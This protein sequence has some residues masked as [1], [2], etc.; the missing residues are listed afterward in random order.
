MAQMKILFSIS[1]AAMLIAGCAGPRASTAA[2]PGAPRVF[3]LNASALASNRGR[4]STELQPAY[5]SL[6]RDADKALREGPFSVMEKK[7]NPPSGDR[8][9][10]MSLAPYFWPNPA[11]K[12]GLPYIRKDGQTNPEVKEYKDKE[13]MPRL[14]ELVHTLGLA[15]YFSGDERYAEHAG[16]LL[17]TWFLDTATRMN[18]NLNFAQAIKGQNT[19]RGA[20]LIDARHFVKV[21]DAIGL[22]GASRSWT[23]ADQ[24]GMQQWFGAFL[25]WMQTSPIGLDELD[26]RNNHGTFYDALRLSM[27][28]YI[29]STDLARRIV[30]SAQ[31]RLDYQMD[32]EGKFPKEMERTIA[33]HYNTFNL[34]AYFQIASMAEKLGIDFWKYRT[35]SGA[36]LEKGFN[37]L[38]PYLS[39]EKEW[40]GQQIKSFDFDEA[41][42]ILLSA[43]RKY[44][45]TPCPQKVDALAAGKAASLRWKLLY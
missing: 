20:G 29:D 37:Y 43:A 35:P 40:T 10:Y 6:L 16:K 33:L 31:D 14:C 2:A 8:H 5:A 36:S 1:L 39:K 26:A 23:T 17:R 32:A 27:A 7:N 4:T 34:D 18:P 9:D 38:Y 24:H 44:N 12:D 42:P 45:C 21:V 30:R 13:Y 15:Y 19:G 3:V 25:N 22:I 41:Y 28:L 11:T